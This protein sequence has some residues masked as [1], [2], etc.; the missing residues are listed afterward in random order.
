MIWA[1]SSDAPA[2]CKIAVLS[3]RRGV[4]F[5]LTNEYHCVEGVEDNIYLFSCGNKQRIA[6]VV[7]VTVF[8]E[9]C[10]ICLSG[11]C[12]QVCPP[13][14]PERQQLID[15]FLRDHKVQVDSWLDSTTRPYAF[16]RETEDG[17]CIFFDAGQ[18][19]CRIH[20]VKPETC[21]A[22]PITFD[23]DVRRERISW[24]MKSSVDCLLAAALRREPERLPAYLSIAKTAI[25]RLIRGLEP[26]ALS[27][28]LQIDEPTVRK[29]GDDF[30][31]FTPSIKRARDS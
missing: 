17:A 2:A 12:R 6:G 25:R 24:F 31:P 30:F 1:S 29:V 16:P 13:I 21:R 18:R 7:C 22:G 4:S 5:I 28:L 27:A 10:T 11:C 9:L 20:P 3:A 26:A 15:H 8:S 19:T 23:L 14:T